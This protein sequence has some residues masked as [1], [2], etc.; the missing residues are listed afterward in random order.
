MRPITPLAALSCLIFM[1]VTAEAQHC[2]PIDESYLGQVSI[3]HAAGNQALELN[4]EYSKTGGQPKE[5]YQ[6]YLLAYLEKNADR[7]PAPSPADLIDKQVVRVLHTQAIERNDRGTYEFQRRL[8]MTELAKSVIELGRLTEKDREDFGGWGRYKD[9]V[10]LAVFVPYLED[11]TYSVL[12]ELPAYKHECPAGGGAGE[13]SLLFQPLPYSL[14]IHFGAA[15]GA[16]LPEGAKQDNVP[17]MLQ[18]LLTDRFK[19]K[20]HRDTKEHAVLALIPGR[21]GPNALLRNIGCCGSGW[22]SAVMK[23]R[24]GNSDISAESAMWL[25]IAQPSSRRKPS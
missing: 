15:H 8:L 19:L 7:V 1:I 4:V 9:R 3:R 17:E 23:I 10:R 12:A 24:N 20:L 6:V 5:K 25:A 22:A 2:P 16:K 14:S 13:R 11:K 21:N 18:A